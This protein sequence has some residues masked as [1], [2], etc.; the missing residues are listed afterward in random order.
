M[1]RLSALFVT[2]LLLTLISVISAAAYEPPI[3]DGY[4]LDISQPNVTVINKGVDENGNWVTSSDTYHNPLTE[5]Q[6]AKFNGNKFLV[7]NYNEYEEIDTTEY[8]D[9]KDKEFFDAKD[10]I[11]DTA[12]TN[13]YDKTTPVNLTLDL[14]GGKS[15]TFSKNSPYADILLSE[16][17]S[18]G[19]DLKIEAKNDGTYTVSSAVNTSDAQTVAKTLTIEGGYEYTN[20][21]QTSFD[22]DDAPN[23]YIDRVNRSQDFY[24]IPLSG[25]YIAVYNGKCSIEAKAEITPDISLSISYSKSNNDPDN[26]GD[27][28]DNRDNG[29]NNN[30]N[31]NENGN[32]N[33]G[34]NN[35]N[36]N[37]GSKSEITGGNKKNDSLPTGDFSF[38]NYI[39]ILLVI[40]SSLFFIVVYTNKKSGSKQ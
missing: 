12:F 30:N 7:K 36:E 32:S 38:A 9:F 10:E 14:T 31:N 26:D 27:N 17:N 35:N 5:D 15:F 24:T 21:P 16:A 13:V 29:D 18:I 19:S 25:Y 33:N 22:I 11:L 1:K 3:I 23:N 6:F 39:I 8:P 20:D 28:G 34:N 40:V 2:A 4:S 37:G